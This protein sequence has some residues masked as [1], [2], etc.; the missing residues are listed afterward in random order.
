MIILMK[1]VEANRTIDFLY[2]EEMC[3]LCY[4][5]YLLIDMHTLQNITSFS[6]S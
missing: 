6:S 5:F 2:A 1:L 4:V 3:V